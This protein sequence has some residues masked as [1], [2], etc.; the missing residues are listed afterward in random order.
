MS[1]EK[2]PKESFCIMPWVHMATEPNGDAKICCLANKKL[3]NNSEI[4]NL[5]KDD[6]IEIFN[7]DQIRKNRKDMLEGIKI[8]ECSQ[9]WKE[10]EAGGLSQRQTATEKWLEDHPETVE[11][12]ER[13]IKDDYRI[14]QAPMYYDFRFGNL[15]NLKC[16]SCGSLNSIQINKEYTELNKEYVNGKIFFQTDLSLHMIMIYRAYSQI[17]KN[18]ISLI[19]SLFLIQTMCI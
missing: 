13:A 19:M 4:F 17:K 10:E 3:Q 18:L 16:R 6:I 9:C 5:G 15:C 1:E 12:I 14:D 2:F 11:I 8:P 7:S